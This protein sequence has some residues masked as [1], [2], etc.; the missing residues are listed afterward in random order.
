M[1]TTPGPLPVASPTASS[2]MLVGMFLLLGIIAAAIA[3]LILKPDTRPP[4]FVLELGAGG[5]L[6]EEKD[7]AL[8]GKRLEG[9]PTDT[10]VTDKAYGATSEYYLLLEKNRPVAQVYKVTDGAWVPLTSSPTYKYDLTVSEQDGYFG[11][12][13]GTVAT[14]SEIG[15]YT[16]WRAVVTDLTTLEEVQRGEGTS[17]EAVWGKYTLL[18]QRADGLYATPPFQGEPLLVFAVGPR[19]PYAVDGSGSRFAMYNS[20]SGA[21]DVFVM[22]YDVLAATYESSTVV[23]SV[24]SALAFKGAA[25]QG[26][27]LNTERTEMTYGDLTG[28][29]LASFVLPTP[30]TVT[31]ILP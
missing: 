7:G 25:V 21:V 3:F 19:E 6:L 14:S 29:S 28:R 4:A 22:R 30:T 18:V 26:V 10:L 27:W 5:V 12:I 11:F 24:P 23:D 15:M 31:K 20:I 16:D 13:A 2:P 8:I 17:I 1:D 9:Q